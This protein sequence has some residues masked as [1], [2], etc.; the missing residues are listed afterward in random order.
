MSIEEYL[1]GFASLGAE[2]VLWLLVALS[3]VAVAIVVE[4]IAFLVISADDYRKLRAD[5]RA[6]LSTGDVDKARRRLDESPSCEARILGAGLG[7]ANVGEA[8]ERMT[9]ESELQRLAMERRVAFLGT[10]GNNAPFIGLLGTVI[11]IIGAFHQL[12]ASQGRLSAGLMA[13]I[14]EALVATAIGLVVALPAV[15]A[16][17][18]F[19]RVIRVRLARANALGRELLANFHAA[20][21]VDPAE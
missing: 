20:Q 10:L 5:L 13:E 17:N 15:A 16:F 11:G 12:D 6:L 2:W 3:V 18:A 1:K 21:A 9:G 4:R 19:Q 7:A 8:E 14:G